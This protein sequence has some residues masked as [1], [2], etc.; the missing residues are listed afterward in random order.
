MKYYKVIKGGTYD[1]LTAFETVKNELLT[2]RER[3]AYCPSIPDRCFVKVN[4]GKTYTV[5]GMRFE[6]A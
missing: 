1:R 2:E 4:V 5:F 6:E 3:R